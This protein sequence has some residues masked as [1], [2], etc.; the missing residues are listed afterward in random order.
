[1]SRSKQTQMVLERESIS[2][3]RHRRQGDGARRA[4]VE[5]RDLRNRYYRSD[6]ALGRALG[7]R[8]DT[9]AVWLSRDVARPRI[10][11]RE[12]V[13]RLLVLC[14]SAGEWVG[15][16]LL[17][18]DWTLELQQL[19]ADRSPAE[20][21]CVLGDEG[22]QVT[23]GHLARIAPRTPVEDLE[24]PSVEQLRA[25]LRQTLG[26]DTRLLVDRARNADRPT[27]DLS[28]FA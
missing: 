10:E 8:P 2:A 25:A 14:K 12:Q 7:W 24:L 23:L 6:A 15:D 4:I 26:E 16:P 5:L 19:L 1:M 11:R 9:V 28:D 21:L 22:L 13:H 17:V 20:V 3:R 27:A 18:G